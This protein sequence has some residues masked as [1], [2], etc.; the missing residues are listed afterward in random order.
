MGVRA[1]GPKR[2]RMTAGWRA[3]SQAGR[4]RGKGTLCR[5][6]QHPSVHPSWAPFYYGS[7]PGAATEPIP[8][9]PPPRAMADTGVLLWDRPPSGR[10]RSQAAAAT[11]RCL[12]HRRVGGSAQSKCSRRVWEARIGWVRLAQLYDADDADGGNRG[13]RRRRESR[14]GRSPD[15]KEGPGGTSGATPNVGVLAKQDAPCICGRLA[16]RGTRCLGS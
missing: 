7:P 14:R 3:G 6:I 4:N 8:T 16:A 13:G 2:A 9:N 12:A 5:S 1:C 11:L 15:W 10:L